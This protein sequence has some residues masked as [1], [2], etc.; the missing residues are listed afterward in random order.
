M[1]D[2]NP[3]PSYFGFRYVLWILWGNAI[4]LLGAAQGGLSTLLAATMDE[5]NPP[6]SP[7]K[8]VIITAI[9]GALIA[10]LANI[11]RNKPA[12]MKPPE[13]QK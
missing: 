1:S 3:V 7:L 6:I 11:N 2:D 13:I 9:N 5:K 8:I 10:A 4:T 12:P